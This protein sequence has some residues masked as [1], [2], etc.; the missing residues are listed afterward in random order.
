MVKTFI[1]LFISLC[2]SLNINAQTVAQ[3]MNKT[4]AVIGRQGGCRASFNMSSPKYGSSAGSIAI[5]GNK[6]NARTNKAIVWYNGKTQWSYMKSTNE[7]NVSSPNR[8]R[9]MS[10]NPMSF[11]NIYKTG[12]NNSMTKKGSNYIVHLTAKSKKRSIQ[13]MYI[14]ISKRT[15]VPSKV[16]MRQGK[17]WSTI[18]ISNFK[19]VNQSNSTFTF[20]AKDYPT[21]EVIDLR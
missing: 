18:T 9:Q 16:R 11:I 10:L 19:A 8:D 1:F 20:N 13:E 6:F 7:V 17:T 14:T 12:F 4:A 2:L 21:A 15:N 5:K 3:V